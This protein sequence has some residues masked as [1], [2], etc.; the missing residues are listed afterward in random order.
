MCS[1]QALI[2][3]Q[4]LRRAVCQHKHRSTT[5]A[6]LKRNYMCGT[7]GREAAHGGRRPQQTDLFSQ[8]VA[9]LAFFVC[10]VWHRVTHTLAQALKFAFNVWNASRN[11][12][13]F[14]CAA[15]ISSPEECRSTMIQ[16]VAIWTISRTE[17]VINTTNCVVVQS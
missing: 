12:Q 2:Q 9:I 14:D 11:N 4:P 16:R 17:D 8:L 1:V 3:S 5:L 10:S 6:T 15:R 7:N 13:K